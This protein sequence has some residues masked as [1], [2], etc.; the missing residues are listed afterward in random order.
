MGKRS[1]SKTKITG[2]AF[3]G[4]RKGRYRSGIFN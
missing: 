3:A 1:V 4:K 2:K